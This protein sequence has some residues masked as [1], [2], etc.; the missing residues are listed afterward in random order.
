MD[1]FLHYRFR[2]RPR[3]WRRHSGVHVHVRIARVVEHRRIERVHYCCGRH[4]RGF[5]SRGGS[6]HMSHNVT[7]RFPSVSVCL[8][9]R[10]RLR[11][12]TNA[13]SPEDT[14]LYHARIADTEYLVRRSMTKGYQLF[15]I[16]TPPIYAGF[17]LFR[18]G[19]GHLTVNRLLRATWLGGAAGRCHSM[20]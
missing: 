19:R 18:K 10:Q 4:D 12:P 5:W 15:S 16:L 3:F 11:L 14:E 1:V 20:I 8:P 17:S 9:G 13:M 2:L 7:L 6:C